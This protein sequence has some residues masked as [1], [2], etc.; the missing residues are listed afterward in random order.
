MPF[1]TV[2]FMNGKLIDVDRITV[3]LGCDIFIETNPVQAEQILSRRITSEELLDTV[4]IRT[5]LTI[6]KIETWEA[7]T[8]VKK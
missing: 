7:A 1:G 8:K 3:G 2:A 6:T 4:A 5:V